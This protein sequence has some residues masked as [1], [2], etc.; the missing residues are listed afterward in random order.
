M[1]SQELAE[2]WEDKDRMLALE[3]VERRRS[4]ADVRRRVV[5]DLGL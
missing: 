4:A 5:K 1:C 3:P 2:K